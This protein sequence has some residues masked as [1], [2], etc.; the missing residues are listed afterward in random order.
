[1]DCLELIFSASGGHSDAVVTHSPVTYEVGGSNPRPYVGNLVVVYR[2]S[3]IYS[4]EP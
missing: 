3:A 4:T 1:M 2:W